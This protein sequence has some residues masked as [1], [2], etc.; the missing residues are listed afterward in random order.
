[1]LETRKKYLRSI[2]ELSLRL[3]AVGGIQELPI[4][5]EF[6]WSLMKAL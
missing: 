6:N 5:P 3:S 2:E 4:P 1:V